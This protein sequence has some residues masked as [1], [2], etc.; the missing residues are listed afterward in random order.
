MIYVLSGGGSG[1]TLVI[2]G[3]AGD[4]CTITKD[5]K[6]KSKTFDSSGKA[7]FKGLDT[8]TW[9]VKMASSSGSTATRTITIN[10][11]YTL[12]ISY[13]SAMIKVT[14]PAT[15]KCVIKNSSG[16]TV[17]SN[18]NTGSSAKTWA[19]T[20]DASGT[21]TVTATSTSDSSK[22]STSTV[23]ITADGQTKTVTLA[24]TT[25][26]NAGTWGSLADGLTKYAARPNAYGDADTSATTIT[27]NASNISVVNTGGGTMVALN[28]EVDLTNYN[29]IKIWMDVTQQAN[30]CQLTVFDGTGS[31]W[32]QNGYAYKE[33]TAGT[34]QTVSLDVKSIT[35]S[36]KIGI[37][38]YG[39]VSLSIKQMEVLA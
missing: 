21:Y 32:Y 28:K 6:S 36:H 11:D 1:A 27:Y 26:Y 22:T 25:I 15:S 38:V 37:G 18:T 16:T 39:G 23:S 17:A 31:D 20:V 7:T 9:T 29:T 4:T 3:V 8:G 30:L 14:Y 2:T 13:F 24:Y 19:A 12:T 10:A 33:I 5:S 34:G 35:G